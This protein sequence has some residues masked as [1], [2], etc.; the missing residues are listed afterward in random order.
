MKNLTLSPSDS[1]IKLD[2]IQLSG[3]ENLTIDGDLSLSGNL[4][5]G[6]IDIQGNTTLI[7]DANLTAVGTPLQQR[8]QASKSMTVLAPMSQRLLCPVMGMPGQ[9]SYLLMVKQPSLQIST[10]AWI[11]L[12]FQHHQVH[13][14]SIIIRPLVS[15]MTLHYRV[16]SRSPLWPTVQTGNWSWMYQIHPT[17]NSLE[18]MRPLGVIPMETCTTW[19]L[20]LVM[21]QH[22][23]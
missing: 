5:A 1:F 6:D 21:P 9:W 16:T 2:G 17:S 18:T 4:S 19:L 15:G 7:G 13:S 11:S 20:R 23:P 14:I 12:I 3:V 10:V 22:L 8:V